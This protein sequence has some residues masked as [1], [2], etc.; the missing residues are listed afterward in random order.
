MQSKLTSTCHHTAM[1]TSRYAESY[2]IQTYAEYIQ[3][4]QQDKEKL[5][6]TAKSWGEDGW[7][8]PHYISS[9][10]S[11]SFGYPR[12]TCADVYIIHVC[13]FL[14]NTLAVV[15]SA[16]MHS[17]CSYWCMYGLFLCSRGLRKRS[18]S[19][20]QGEQGSGESLITDG[21]SHYSYPDSTGS[22]KMKTDGVWTHACIKYFP[23]AV[24]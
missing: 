18:I 17:F 13:I 14:P 8:K 15:V 6:Q 24:W 2:K 12:Y 21:W 5:G 19:P 22:K 11:A 7:V 9:A 20:V 4:K 23:A 16:G 3:G 10:T 1:N